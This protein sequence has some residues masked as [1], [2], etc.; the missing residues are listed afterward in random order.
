MNFK[1]FN[2]KKEIMAQIDAVG[3]KEAT[4]IQEQAIPVILEGTDILGLAKTGTGKTATF[5]LPILE[6]IA[7]T[8][9]KGKGVRALII[10]PTRELAEQINN[11]V[12]QL[13]KQ[14]GIKSLAVYGGTSV[15]KQVD[16]L[17]TGVDIVVG[18]PGRILDHINQGNL[19]LTRLEFLV[20]DE[21]DHMLDM[22]FLKDIEK[23]VKHT[24]KKKQTLFFS[25]TMP[26]EIKTLAF[27]V[28]QKGHQ[29]IEVEYKDPVK[30][31]EHELY[32]ID[33]D[34]KKTKLL[35]LL[36]NHEIESVIVFTNGKHKARHLSKTLE[37]KGKKAVN[38][39]G[40][41]SQNQ[42]DAAL[43]GFRNGDYNILVA[44]DIAARGLDI[45]QVTHVINFDLPKTAEAFT[46]RSGRTG[47]ANKNGIVISFS[48][49]DDKKILT[50]ILKVNKINF[51]K[52]HGDEKSLSKKPMTNDRE[53]FRKDSKPQEK[54]KFSKNKNNSGKPQNRKKV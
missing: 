27:K 14:I 43:S 51:A 16:I 42:R 22:G 52:I 50:E 41:L 2:F 13:G 7:T 33:H 23:I 19:G 34:D 48:S 10:A 4:P 25:A 31:I 47:R 15:K 54:S 24:P 21:A 26:K 45:P 18:C 39:Q 28:L 8:K 38:F 12:L 46:H 37:S 29:T 20:L 11:T 3:Y 17:K 36:D 35:E 30:L 40:N 44:T 1:E 6:K 49:I 9:G 32:H 5:V 53:R